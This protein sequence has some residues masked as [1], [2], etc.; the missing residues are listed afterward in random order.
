[1]P[2]V[3]SFGARGDGVSLDTRAIQD[4]I[5][6]GGVVNFPPGVYRTGTIYLRSNGGLHLENGAVILGSSNPDDY[7]PDDFCPQNRVFASEHVSGAHLV[8]AV[9]QE[10]ISLSGPGCIDGNRQE[11][12][13]AEK[14]NPARQSHFDYPRW[15]PG[16]MLFFCECRNLSIEGVEL[17]NATYWHSFY[18]GCEDVRIRGLYIHSDLRTPTNDGIDLDCCQRVVV[19]D[20]LISTGDDCLTLRGNVLPLKKPRVCR[21][22]TVSNCVFQTA[23]CAIRVGVGRGEIRDCRIAD[24]VVRD[25][26]R[27]ICICPLFSQGYTSIENI[28]FCNFTIDAKFPLYITSNWRGEVHDPEARTVQDLYFRNIQARARGGNL[29]V[30]NSCGKMRGL[31]FSDLDIILQDC[32]ADPELDYRDA[33]TIW[34]KRLSAAPA[35]ALYIA[36]QRN[37]A[38]RNVRVRQGE[39]CRGFRH[40]A[41]FVD[42]PGAKLENC[43]FP[44]GMYQDGSLDRP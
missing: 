14:L 33:A 23:T 5:N 1:M 41:A 2:D 7:N 22:I 27:G 20:C 34:Q 31:T 24:I 8:V 3:L 16:Q 28:S 13:G 37:L 42:S 6:A 25:S 21:D 17:R 19:S 12:F 15:R 18:H 11:I 36:H 10:N 38:L 43:L 32:Q 4:A 40:D 9:E 30:G 35:T 26:S 29:I 39:N 44:G